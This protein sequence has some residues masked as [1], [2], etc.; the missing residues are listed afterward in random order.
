MNRLR[1]HDRQ[2]AKGLNREVAEA[3]IA[4]KQET[5]DEQSPEPPTR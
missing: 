5:H 1:P 3:F 2:A 4:E